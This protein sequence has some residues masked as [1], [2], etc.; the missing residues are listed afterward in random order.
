MKLTL[1]LPL[2]VRETI[3]QKVTTQRPFKFGA[4]MTMSLT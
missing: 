4:A 2:L 3:N 1:I